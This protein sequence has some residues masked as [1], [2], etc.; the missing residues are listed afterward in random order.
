M[1]PTVAKVLPIALASFATGSVA[2]LAPLDDGLQQD[3][4]TPI[5][6]TAGKPAFQISLNWSV[7]STSAAFHT[8]VQKA[9]QFYAD[10]FTA[11]MGRGDLPI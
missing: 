7:A 6:L 10:I 8:D 3:R 11:P 5:S 2:V 4:D 1:Y 9:F